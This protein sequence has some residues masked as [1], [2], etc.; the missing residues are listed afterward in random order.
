MPKATVPPYHLFLLP[1]HPSV[2]CS[3]YIRAPATGPHSP[4]PGQGPADPKCHLCTFPSGRAAGLGQASDDTFYTWGCRG[5]QAEAGT[6]VEG[7]PWMERHSSAHFFACDFSEALPWILP[8]TGRAPSV[9]RSPR[10]VAAFPLQ[11]WREH[12]LLE[13]SSTRHRLG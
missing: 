7:V 9:P 10:A 2:S 5:G 13:G 3:L 1:T 8:S 4:Q 12:N 11:I 6:R